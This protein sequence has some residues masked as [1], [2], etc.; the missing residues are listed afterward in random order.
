MLKTADE[1]KFFTHQ[2]NFPL[3]IEFARTCNVEISVVK[4]NNI[5]MLELP[6]LA[7]SICNHGK[8]AE[9]PQYE[10]VEVKKIKLP[11]GHLAR[12][13]KKLL[14]QANIV[15]N[16]VKNKLLKDQSISLSNL[17][18]EFK[19]FGLSKAALC[20]HMTKVRKELISTGHTVVKLKR[21]EYKIKH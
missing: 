2:D 12:Q 19:E 18:S 16:Y 5:K 9:L 21:G 20:N 3:L 6:E 10:V 13:R 1:R 7:R 17:E 14:S 11:K 8:Q 4:V 15:Y